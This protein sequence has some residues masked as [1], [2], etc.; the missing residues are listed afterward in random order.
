M[1]LIDADELKKELSKRISK[2]IKWTMEPDVYSFRA[3][4]IVEMID[5]VPVLTNIDVIKEFPSIVNRPQGEWIKDEEHSITIEM[6]KC[7]I[8]SCWGGANHFNFCPNCGADMRGK[9]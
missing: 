1:K 2:K 4:E 6:F 3:D 7:S 5:S 8:C 9:S